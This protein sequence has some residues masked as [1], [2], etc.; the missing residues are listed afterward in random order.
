MFV[1]YAV[2]AEQEQQPQREHERWIRIEV[3]DTGMGIAPE[4]MPHLFRAFEQEKTSRAFGGLGLGL[5]ISKGTRACLCVCMGDG[6]GV[7]S[8]LCVMNEPPLKRDEVG[9]LSWCSCCARVSAA[10]FMYGLCDCDHLFPC[11]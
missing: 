8:E 4:M 7:A 9:T 6:S 10:F 1:S 2:A 11:V 3:S 5:F